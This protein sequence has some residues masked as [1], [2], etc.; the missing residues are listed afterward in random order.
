ML[1]QGLS[2]AEIAKKRELSEQTIL[3]HFLIIQGDI[4]DYNFD[5]IK[6]PKP[7]II[8]VNEALQK[9]KESDEELYSKNG[10]IKLG[11]IHTILKSKVDYKDIMLALLF[12]E[13]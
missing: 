3:R 1:E 4:P 9:A 8:Q 11:P 6:P 13:K 2:L 10:H 7:L 5:K 12:C